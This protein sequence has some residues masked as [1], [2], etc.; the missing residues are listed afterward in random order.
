MAI[1]NK[2]VYGDSMMEGA[3][4]SE[5]ERTDLGGNK[6]KRLIIEGTAIVCET[7]GINGRKY[8]RRIIAREVERLNRTMVSKGRLAAA[9]NHPRLDEEGMSKDFPIFE[10][11]L[12]RTCALVE[13]LRM[14]GDRLYC[15]MVVA[16]GHP[17]G[18]ALAALIRTGY[19]P[20]Y[21]LR[22]AGD[23]VQEGD[24]EV[25]CDNYVMI[26]IDV[27]GNPSFGDEAIF[28]S[29]MEACKTPAGTKAITESIGNYR[30]EVAA[31][32]A[33]KVGYHKYNK[34]ALIEAMRQMV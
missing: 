8:P 12:M 11:D 15:R 19:R 33:L 1:D 24:H 23:T 13:E 9:L 21:S 7:A 22:G 28:R 10:M 16:E 34:A 20:G 29:Y 4:V 27:V 3:V 31:C 17:A 25:I 2:K 32:A 6:V 30:R 18:D 14:D 26:T 5:V